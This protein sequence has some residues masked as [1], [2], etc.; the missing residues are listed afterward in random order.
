MQMSYLSAVLRQPQLDL[1]P[2]SLRGLNALKRALR[3]TLPFLQICPS[4]AIR[5]GQV[6][7][8][9]LARRRPPFKGLA[10]WVK[11]QLDDQDPA[12]FAACVAKQVADN[13]A[14]NSGP[15]QRGKKAAFQ[16][17]MP[18][19]GVIVGKT[20]HQK[21]YDAFFAAIQAEALGIQQSELVRKGVKFSGVSQD[22]IQIGSGDLIDPYT[23]R[24]R[25]GDSDVDLRSEEALLRLS[26][27]HMDFARLYDG[28]VVKS[29][30]EEAQERAALFAH[31]DYSLLSDELRQQLMES[32]GLF[33][34]W[35]AP[36][37]S[38]EALAES[39]TD[40]LLQSRVME[41]LEKGNDVDDRE[42]VY[43][44]GGIPAFR[45]RKLSPSGPYKP[46]TPT[47]D[48][49]RESHLAEIELSDSPFAGESFHPDQP[50]TST[51]VTTA[52]TH[53]VISQGTYDNLLVRRARLQQEADRIAD[54]M[55]NALEDGDLRESAA[56]DEAR[57]LMFANQRDLREL[58]DELSQVQVGDVAETLIGSTFVLNLAGQERQVKLTDGQPAI[59]EVSTQSPLGQALLTAQP[60]QQIEVQQHVKTSVPTSFPELTP[61]GLFQ[62]KRDVPTGFNS[63]LC[64]DTVQTYALTRK[65]GKREQISLTT[66]FVEVRSMFSVRPALA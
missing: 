18:L 31:E 65:P 28:E 37:K 19:A 38:V 29:R 35:D 41:V 45:C 32:E 48:V 24:T 7:L 13:Q 51:T 40:P 26:R 5:N 14:K 17:T 3:Q 2:T 59:G 43:F 15:R 42:R 44:S 55:G 33:V 1:Q 34:P 58:E 11:A 12:F 52:R 60:G 6:F 8:A 23:V 21:L 66:V 61:A 30:H 57:G 16:R 25:E 22:A 53:R 47:V 56:Y 49:P 36:L 46:Y 10:R 39:I 20:A 63:P 9:V 54:L 27:L 50:S 4:Q 64:P 62:R